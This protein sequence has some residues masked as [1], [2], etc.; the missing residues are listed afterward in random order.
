[1][2]KRTWEDKVDEGDEDND[3]ETK[4]SSE[5]SSEEEEEEEGAKSTVV[6]GNLEGKLETIYTEELKKRLKGV[7]SVSVDWSTRMAM[8][9]YKDE[10]SA[11]E[12]V[13]ETDGTLLFGST[14]S[15][16]PSSG[17]TSELCVTNISAATSDSD[18]RKLMEPHGNVLTCSIKQRDDNTRRCYVRFS[19]PSFAKKA[20]K[21]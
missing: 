6:V 11:A 20:L 19:D 5:S 18:I 13:S 14:I 21:V 12:A 15:A 1:M 8:V 9:E 10:A 4:S 16:G 3:D 2:S 17:K 7:L